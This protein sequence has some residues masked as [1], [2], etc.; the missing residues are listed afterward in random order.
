MRFSGARHRTSEKRQPHHVRSFSAG[1]CGARGIAGQE[2]WRPERTEARV[3]RLESFRAAGTQS[4]AAGRTRGRIVFER[5]AAVR[6]TDSGYR[7]SP[8]S[9]SSPRTMRLRTMLQ[10]AAERAVQQRAAVERW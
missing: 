8:Y 5:L 10:P 1:G 2:V 6:R 7:N 4:N 3:P 9:G